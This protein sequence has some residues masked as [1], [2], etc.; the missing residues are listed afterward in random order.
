MS[1]SNMFD[2]S[3]HKEAPKC[4]AS[5][6]EITAFGGVFIGASCTD[7]RPGYDVYIGFD[8]GMSMVQTF[9]PWE[10]GVNPVNVYYRITDQR[11]PTDLKRFDKLIDWTCNQLQSGKRVHAG[12]I[13]GHGRT[14]L[15]V[16]VLANRV[17]KV[18]DAIDWARANHC[19]KAVET[20]DQINWL[21]KR[22]G[23]KKAPSSHEMFAPKGEVSGSFIT[24][25]EFNAEFG[26]EKP[27]QTVPTFVRPISSAP[28]AMW[29]ITSTKI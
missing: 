20:T 17:L 1:Q 23:I 22:Y 5:H 4:H 18:K 29:D 2:M 13:G 16:A 9:D 11:T 26:F 15:F 3:K 28:T 10:K 6:K 7:P 25:D 24:E 12:C 21:N 19:K 14:G 8:Y 27:A